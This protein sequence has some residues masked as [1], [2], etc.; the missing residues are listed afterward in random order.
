MH[1]DAGR[2]EGVTGR[3]GPEGGRAAGRCAR[4]LRLR[5][6][7]RPARLISVILAG[8]LILGVLGVSGCSDLRLGD[9][10]ADA[11]TIQGEWQVVGTMM[12]FVITDNQIRMPGDVNY[13][14]TIDVNNQTLAFSV[15]SVA[16][17]A[18]YRLTTDKDTGVVTLS[19]VEVL[20]GQ[21]TTTNLVKLSDD[22]KAKP[23]ATGGDSVFANPS[24]Q[25]A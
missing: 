14:Y 24:D 11:T 20:D 7:G 6:H 10:S 15:G 12:T 8:V 16:G 18:D 25:S 3:P 9:H 21:E 2:C 1:G 4:A 19:L 17:S 13:D 23:S 5:G 22:T